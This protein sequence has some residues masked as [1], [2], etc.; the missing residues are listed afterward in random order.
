MRFPAWSAGTVLK[1]W[2]DWMADQPRDTWANAHV[3]TAG[4][5]LS[6]RVFGVCP[7]GLE[8]TR[9]ASLRR[10]VGVSAIS[11]STTTRSHM[12]GI[13]YLGGGSSTPRTKFVAG[14]DILSAVTTGAG[15][16]VESAM[17]DAAARGLSAAA[18]LDPLDGALA[19]P[20]ASATPFPWRSHAAS[21]QWYVGLPSRA[22]SSDYAAAEAW[23]DHAH[24][25]LGSR[26]RGGYMGYLESGRALADYVAG[27]TD[28]LTR[29][30]RYYDP[31][32]VIL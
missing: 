29:V 10:A 15:E 21:V 30:R 32:H 27:N 25:S 1:R 7:A 13:R 9:A 3:D 28:R 16:A 12:D 31:D 26:S 2:G 8:A 17:R 14:S 23:V 22:G 11:T 5:S 18:I 4:S 20:T 6:V 24:A 19:D